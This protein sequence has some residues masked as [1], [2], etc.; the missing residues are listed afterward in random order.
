MSSLYQSI[1]RLFLGYRGESLETVDEHVPASIFLTRR[2]V[3]RQPFWRESRSCRL[4][5]SENHS[6][7]NLGWHRKECP[8]AYDGVCI[9]L[10]FTGRERYH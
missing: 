6:R 1:K 4:F 3:L 9:P 10:K 2:S 8:P 7:R 5:R